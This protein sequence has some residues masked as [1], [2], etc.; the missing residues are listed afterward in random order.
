M[1]IETELKKLIRE[2]VRDELAGIQTVETAD[3][4]DT[5]EEK[6]ETPADAMTPQEFLTQVKSVVGAKKNEARTLLSEKY[7]KSK[8]T[9][10]DP[11]LYEECLEDLKGI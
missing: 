1:S 8:F 4:V 11:E 3:V 2:I 6:T 5:D 9:D 10:V 7:G